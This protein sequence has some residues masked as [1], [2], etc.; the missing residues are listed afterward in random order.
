MCVCICVCERARVR[1]HH[2]LEDVRQSHAEDVLLT[3]PVM[4]D[5]GPLLTHLWVLESGWLWVSEDEDKTRVVP[6]SKRVVAVT[7]TKKT[8]LRRKGFLAQGF[9]SRIACVKA[10]TS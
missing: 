2:T 5:C 6:P 3:P 1:A 9:S 8:V 7:D 10:E 4:R